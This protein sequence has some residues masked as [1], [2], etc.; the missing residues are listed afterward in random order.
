[1]SIPA[2]DPFDLLADVGDCA[3]RA[4]RTRGLR[5]LERPPVR[6]RPRMLYGIVAVIGAVL[7]VAAQMGLSILS[8]Q[9]S[10]EL[11][12]LTQQQQSL[13]YEKQ[14]LTDSI[15]GLSSPQYLAANATALGMITGQAPTY[16]RLSDSTIIG[17]AAG[18]TGTSSIDALNQAA[19][20]N[21]LVADVPL[22]NDPD[23]TLESG[24]SVTD[25]AIAAAADTTTPPAIADGLPTPTTH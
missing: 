1:M 24:A 2:S 20:G 8:T 25:D 17:T 22:V 9:S 23:A 11:A 4:E 6:R 16:L 3:T 12:A 21:A 19:V 10:Y 15:A 7:I 13:E 5:A 14:M 18:A